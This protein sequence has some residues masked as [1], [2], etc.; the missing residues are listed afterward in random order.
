M[1]GGY[2]PLTGAGAQAEPREAGLFSE[3]DGAWRAGDH[4]FLHYGT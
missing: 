2:V 4:V 1:A 3:A